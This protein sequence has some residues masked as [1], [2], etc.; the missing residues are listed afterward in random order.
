M[1]TAE[2]SAALDR[3]DPRMESVRHAGQ[4]LIRLTG[5]QML[6]VMGLQTQTLYHN[7]EDRGGA[8]FVLRNWYFVNVE[9][10]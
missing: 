9:E 5:S 6:L 7:Y 8:P 3:L 10:T 1:S 2:I 4:H